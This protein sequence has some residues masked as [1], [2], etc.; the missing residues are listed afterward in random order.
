M[1]GLGAG[2]ATALEHARPG[3]ITRVVMEQLHQRVGLIGQ[4][5]RL[6]QRVAVDVT[7]VAHRLTLANLAEA[8]LRRALRSS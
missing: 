4:T 1:N 5:R 7:G 8:R 6:A 3:G 2:A